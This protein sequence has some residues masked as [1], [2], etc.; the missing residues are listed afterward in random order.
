[1]CNS[2]NVHLINATNMDFKL[3]ATDSFV[4]ENLGERHGES[5]RV[6]SLTCIALFI[7]P[8][9]HRYNIALCIRITNPNKE[10]HSLN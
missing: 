4:C 5:F 6:E 8:Y 1:M 7:P 10:T 9:Q 3:P 2:L